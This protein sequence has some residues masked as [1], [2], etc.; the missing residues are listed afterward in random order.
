MNFQIVVLHLK[1]LSNFR[2]LLVW[3]YFLYAFYFSLLLFC[4]ICCGAAVC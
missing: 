4:F 2:I 3:L 1:I